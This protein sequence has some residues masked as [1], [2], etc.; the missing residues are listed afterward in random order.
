MDMT[1]ILKIA[2]TSFMQSKMSGDSGSALDTDTLISALSRLSG[3][4]SSSNNGFDI[5]D[6]L[7][8]MQSGG[9][10]DI[11]QSWLGDGQNAEISDN[12]VTEMLG[13]D[14]ISDFASQLGLSREEATGGLR[15]A[16]PQMVDKG[17]SGGSLLDSIG[18]IDGAINLVSKI[19][20][21]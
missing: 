7:G 2:A 19:F 5:G 14:K 16:L 8:K 10:A 9:M 15:D 13:E 3:S 17:S 18:G 21:R 12:Q 4:N 11:A 1:N 6:L 20:G